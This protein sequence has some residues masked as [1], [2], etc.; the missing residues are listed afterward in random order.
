MARLDGDLFSHNFVK[1]VLLD[2]THDALSAQSDQLPP[3]C[4]PVVRESWAARA[5]IENACLAS[6]R[7]AGYLYHWHAKSDLEDC[8]YVGAVQA[9]AL[10]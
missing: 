5:H 8:I 4:Y 3:E 7:E 6:A 10:N 1:L 2:A 9:S